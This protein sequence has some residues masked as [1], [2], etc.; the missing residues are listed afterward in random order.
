MKFTVFQF[1]CKAFFPFFGCHGEVW[2]S[3]TN[4]VCPENKIP[5]FHYNIPL[6]ATK[7]ADFKTKII[8]IIV[9]GTVKDYLF[10]AA[11]LHLS[12]KDLL[13]SVNVFSYFP[14]QSLTRF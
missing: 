2:L 11:Y 13:I 5:F 10:S 9:Y 3:F 1:L 8:E 4:Q 14:I 7:T 12:Q 6:Y